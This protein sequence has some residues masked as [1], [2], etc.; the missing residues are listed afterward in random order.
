MSSKSV[1]PVAVRLLDLTAVGA[2]LAVH[3]RCFSAL[4][5]ASG[6]LLASVYSGMFH[7]LKALANN[8]DRTFGRCKVV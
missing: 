4:L 6:F 7:E 2:A 8:A 1:I 3:S 5:T